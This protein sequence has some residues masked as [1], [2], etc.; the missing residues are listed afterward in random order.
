[1]YDVAIIGLGP[2]GS[3]LARLL[4]KNLKVIAIDTGSKK[5]CGG[6]LA[7]DAQKLLS[8]F[9]LALPK[10]V[11]ADPQIFSVRTID[12][13][14]GLIRHY[15]RFYINMNRHKF[16]LWLKSLIPAR[17]EILSN[18]RCTDIR[19]EHG[20]WVI[21]D[22]IKAKYLVGA[23]GANSVVRRTICKDFKIR[24]YT[25]IQQGFESQDSKPFYLS[26]FDPEI[27][28]CYAWGLNKDGVFI[29]GGAFP[30]TDSRKLFEALKK[31]AM[32]FGFDLQ[33]PLFTEACLVNRPA[34]PFEFYTGS[35]NV[36]LIGEAAGLI[37]PSSLE[38]ISYA[39]NSALMLSKAFRTSQ[40]SFV[41]SE[42]VR[43]IKRNL[44]LK[45]LK[46]PFMY[47]PSIRNI[48]MKSGI[49]SIKR[50]K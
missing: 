20:Y 38:G 34:N 18:T 17:V 48:I 11:L 3:T 7:P 14:T 50:R 36:F 8:R 25:A 19:R 39:M 32:R 22:T 10:S 46:C 26:I 12:F 37:S 30:K 2:A 6:L 16:D 42:L 1:M 5:P 40:P 49:M 35:K 23:D 41:Y 33:N 43:E 45:L 29:F 28:D 21:N 24:Q 13:K 27:T 47:S 4:P 31:K 9:D 15:P 44:T